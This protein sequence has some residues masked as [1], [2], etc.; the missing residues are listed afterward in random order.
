MSSGVDA[1][2]Q[3]RHRRQVRSAP[4]R[5]D[6]ERPAGGPGHRAEPIVFT[7][8]H[9]DAHGGDTNG[10]GSATSPAPGDWGGI[11][12]TASS[13]G[14]VLDHTWIGYGGYGGAPY[15]YANLYLFTS[16]ATVQNS[17]I[18]WSSNRGIQVDNALPRIER[19][20]F[21]TTR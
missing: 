6:R 4:R 18:A 14:S 12:L 8:L 3:P 20:G 15:A 11:A 7:S 17:T 10:D 13:S 5:S 1:D 2:L 9:D 16:D 19:I 21:R